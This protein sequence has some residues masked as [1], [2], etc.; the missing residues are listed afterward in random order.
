MLLNVLKRLI[1][2]LVITL[3]ATIFSLSEVYGEPII[4]D[5]DYLIERFVGGLKL[6]TTMDFVGDDILVLEKNT[7]KV[8]RIMNNGIIYDKPVLDVPVRSNFYSGLL[9]IVTLSDRVFLYY[10]ESE[11][12]SDTR[13]PGPDAKNRVYQYDWD[14]VKLTNPILIKELIAQQRD[15]HHGGVMTKGLNDEIYF[16]IG[17]Q[18]QLG[19]FENVVEN[20]C[21]IIHFVNDECS[22]EPIYETSSIF[23]IHTDDNNSVEL[24]AMGVRNSFGLGVDPVTG[25]LWDTENGKDHFD[26]I[27]LVKPRFNSGW[28]NVMGPVDRK[29]PDPSVSQTIPPPFENFIYSDPEFSW[30]EPVGP[31]AIAFPDLTSFGKYSDWLF[32]GDYHHGRIYKFQLNSDRTEFIFSDQRLSDLVLD[33]LNDKVEKILFGKNFLTVSDIAFRH[34]AMYVVSISDGSIY[35]IYPKDPITPLKQY[36]VGSTHKKIVCKPGLIPIMKNSGYINCAY[37]KTALVLTQEIAWDINRSDMPIIN[38]PSH[39]LSGINFEHINLSYSNFR[40]SNFTSTNIANA[41]FTSANLSGVDLSMKDL[42]ENILTGAD[43]RNANLAGADLSNNQ[44]VN[45]I[46]TGTDLT[47]ANLS[48]A[49]LSTANIFGI[50]DGINVLEKTKLKGANL[51]NANLTNINLI[52]VDISETI[53]KGA[54]LTGVKL[55]R[56]KANNA[57]WS[58]VDLSF[59]NLSK[60]RLIDA[61]LNR[62]ILAGAELSNAELMGANL[63]D[64]DL[65]GAKLIDA[66]L[67]NANLTGANFHMADLTGANLEGVIINETNLS[68]IGHDICTS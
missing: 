45:T 3:T 32:V 67:T 23:R 5:D 39:D 4:F 33:K 53:L 27:N 1:I 12:G 52:G 31:T 6:P 46:L 54:D 22:S 9:G 7:G 36:Q 64:A 16:A 21:Y 58:D 44:L 30:Y 15:D 29:N 17:D 65:T 11:S 68:C 63:S 60:I 66:D 14:G 51:T 18:N 2:F 26:E 55:E 50:I 13:D 34:D 37:P 49:D 8:I 59:K 42:T 24:F 47:D 62:S 43:L 41:N 25:Y 19:V 40:E 10:T 35:K 38:L 56:A 28:N 48:G 57:T 20:P 61:S